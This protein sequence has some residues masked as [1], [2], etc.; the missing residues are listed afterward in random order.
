MPRIPRALRRFLRH[1]A[2]VVGGGVLLA[3]VLVA[4]FAPLVAPHDPLAIGLGGR[5]PPGPDF[6]FGTDRLGRDIFSRVVFG[7]RISLLV[8][9]V[10]VAIGLVAGSALGL[11]AGYYG[12]RVDTL[13]MRVVDAML[14]LP[15]ILLALVVIAALG[16]SLLNVMIAVGIGAIPQYA[17]LAR[18]SALSVRE[19]PFVEA[20]RAFGASDA[21]IMVQHVL[22][23]IAAPLIVLSTLQIGQAIL[24]GS[25]LSFL[26]MGAQPPT[27]EWGAMTAYGR[28]YLDRSWWMSTFPGLAILSVVV[29]VNLLGEGLREALDPNLRD[30]R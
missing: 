11:I 28:D 15:G 20:A 4:I 25:G 26:G 21:R 18:G 17:R 9:V 16:P 19:R 29:A 30:V 6:W 23:G 14:A 13:I 7:A 8:G 1:R 22:P 27:P 24:V 5:Q 2:A 12:G 10:S 3:W